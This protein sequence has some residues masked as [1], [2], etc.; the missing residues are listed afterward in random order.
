MDEPSKSSNTRVSVIVPTRNSADVLGA[1]LASISGQTRRA[2]E[3]IVCDAQ[4]TDG[5]K[6]IASSY[7]ASVVD[8]V[9]N[10]SAQRNRGADLASGDFLVF[11]DSDMQ[12]TPRVLEDCLDRV[13]AEDAA[14]V[15]H[16]VFVGDGFWAHVRS[17]ERSFYDG[18]WWIEAARF[19]RASA[20]RTVGGFD[21]SMIG[22]EDWDLDQRIRTQGTVGRTQA[23]IEHNEGQTSFGRLLKK[24]AHYAGSMSSFAL[25]HPDRANRALSPLNRVKLFA[26]QPAKLLAHPARTAGLVGLG[27]AEV[28]VVHGLGKS[29]DQDSSELARQPTP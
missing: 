2:D 23:G 27:I 29:W 4:S 10:R 12:L 13:T 26:R 8:H 1:C 25:R 19:Y 24:K 21:E 9:P 22:P 6:E 28:A 18:V 20:F 17:H 3:V 15:I 11:I 14:L 16:E 5:T 7:G